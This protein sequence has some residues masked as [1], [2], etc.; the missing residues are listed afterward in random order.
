MFRFQDH[1]NKKILEKDET[2][3][4]SKFLAGFAIFISL[5]G[6]F[7]SYLED[8]LL[9]GQLVGPVQFCSS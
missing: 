3:G 9:A 1:R 8:V 7:V 2:T 4:L 5:F 6:G